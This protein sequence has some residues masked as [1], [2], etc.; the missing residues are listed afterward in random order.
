MTD[1]TS[2]LAARRHLFAVLEEAL[3]AIGQQRFRQ[4][5]L[6]HR[7]R[8]HIV[9]WFKQPSQF[10][11]ASDR[12][13]F[14]YDSF[15]KAVSDVRFDGVTF[16]L[17]NPGDGE[18][19]LLAEYPQV[20]D[21]ITTAVAEVWEDTFETSCPHTAQLRQAAQTL[22]DAI[23][24]TLVTAT[25][26]DLIRSIRTERMEVVELLFDVD[27]PIAD[28]DETE[29]AALVDQP[30]ESIL[31][32]DEDLALILPESDTESTW[33]GLSVRVQP[34]P[35]EAYVVGRDDT[36][37]GFFVHAVDG[38]NLT[39]TAD[40]T[41]DMIRDAMGFD[42]EVDP[43]TT[44]L[45]PDENECIRVQGDL[46]IERIRTEEG[47]HD[48]F[49]DRARREVERSVTEEFVDRY[50][51]KRGLAE[52]RD[53]RIRGR[54]T[55]LH[56]SLSRSS[57]TSEAVAAIEHV[58]MD[59]SEN[60]GQ[61]QSTHIGH[62]QRVTQLLER[63]LANYLTG[64]YDE[65]TE[66]VE[67]RLRRR[68]D[69]ELGECDQLNLPIDN[70]LV[71]LESARLHP[72]ENGR[73]EPVEIVVPDRTS[74]HVIHDEHPQVDVHLRPGTYTCQLLARGIQ[75]PAERPVW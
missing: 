45:A 32:R 62:S 48:W 53:L 40:V 27:Q 38:T 3:T 10:T 6:A 14:T 26:D 64:H 5:S 20:L 65:Y 72:D 54:G 59:N 44:V 29:L 49:R 46:C 51:R 37:T 30:V 7:L 11:A 24:E 13:A 9:H 61:S 34:G 70:H 28:Q 15:R 67:R 55:D 71:I 16:D 52:Y 4:Q 41:R 42:R 12:L 74:L 22:S 31:Y 39:A 23:T 66:T 63:R 19:S 50:L 25:L 68:V 73:Q 47:L 56:V 21:G 57:L 17:H 33:A 75:P 58:F 2:I 1:Y 18:V 60:Q 8:I 35:R 43:D 69:D 36:P